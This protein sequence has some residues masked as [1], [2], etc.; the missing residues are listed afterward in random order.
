MLTPDQIRLRLKA[1]YGGDREPCDGCLDVMWLLE[2]ILPE[3]VRVV[4]LPTEQ[5][6]AQRLAVA[7]RLHPD[8]HPDLQQKMREI[9][10]KS[11]ELRQAQ[12][13]VA[14]NTGTSRMIEDSW[15]C[16]VCRAVIDVACARHVET[17]EHLRQGARTEALP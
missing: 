9:A 17:A 14:P 11:P 3:L 13:R 15:W 1:I 6:Q 5:E 4:T 2:E 7:F 16:T 8:R 12:H 10:G